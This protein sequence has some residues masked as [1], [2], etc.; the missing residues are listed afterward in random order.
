[1]NEQPR[2]TPQELIDQALIWLAANPR[3]STEQIAQAIGCDDADLGGLLT[4]AYR[5]GKVE[6][7]TEGY[8]WL[9]EVIP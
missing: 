3:K 1:M 4:A 8:P 9:W 7:N 6:P 5:A 2:P